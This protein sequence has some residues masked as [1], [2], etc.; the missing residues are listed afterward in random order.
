MCGWRSCRRAEISGQ[1]VRNRPQLIVAHATISGV[2]TTTETGTDP[3]RLRRSTRR[4]I[5]TLGVLDG[6]RTPCGEAIP[7][8]QAHA[9]MHLL[10]AARDSRPMRHAD[11]A[12]ELSLNKSSVSRMVQRL[13]DSGHVVEHVDPDD[14]RA[15]V[16]ELTTS[17]RA[18]AMQVDRAS[19]DLFTSIWNAIPEHERAR[20]QRSVNTLAR[21]AAACNK[22]DKR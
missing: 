17:G 11:L 21:A 18:L 16:I 22:G 14:A 8:S 19:L 6:E 4:L 10:G 5:R 13:L 7:V 1:M 12:C 15:R 9:L 3:D 20:V 2:P